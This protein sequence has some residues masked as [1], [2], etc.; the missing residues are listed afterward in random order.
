M[1]LASLVSQ[2]RTYGAGTWVSSSRL[3]R[4]ERVSPTIPQQPAGHY[5]SRSVGCNRRRMFRSVSY[6]TTYTKL[7]MCTTVACVFSASLHRVI[8][9]MHMMCRRLQRVV[10]YS[11]KQHTSRSQNVLE[12]IKNKTAGGIGDSEIGTNEE[13]DARRGDFCCEKPDKS[14]TTP[15]KVFGRRSIR[16]PPQQDT[17]VEKNMKTVVLRR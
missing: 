11:Y 13:R 14:A 15:R 17:S 4:S 16:D 6:Q 2:R 5:A 7:M 10:A 12:K 1:R 3:R 9:V 8:A